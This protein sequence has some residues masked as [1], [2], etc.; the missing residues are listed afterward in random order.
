MVKI[1][2]EG[3]KSFSLQQVPR[4][5]NDRADALAK[6]ANSL[7]RSRDRRITFLIEDPPKIEKMAWWSR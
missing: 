5:E 2:G 6:S 4:T 7:V 1:L 3:F